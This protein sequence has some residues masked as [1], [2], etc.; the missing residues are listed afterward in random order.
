M[1]IE[2]TAK[3]QTS[4]WN[5][6]LWIAQGLLAAMYLMTGG[7]KTGMPPEAMVKMGMA[8]VASAPVGLLRLIGVLELLGGLGIVLPAATRILPWLTPAAGVGL[9][10]VQVGALVLHCVRGETGSLGMNL[11]LL[12]LSAFVVW[13]RLKKAPVPPR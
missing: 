3:R 7:M 5:V 13:G 6:G 2:M 4:P 8:W 11:T 1:S 12:A 9:S 10:L